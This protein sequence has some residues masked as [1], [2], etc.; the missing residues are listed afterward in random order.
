MTGITANLSLHVDTLI[1]ELT[2]DF[3]Y[4]NIPESLS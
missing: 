4:T 2:E 3:P 1:V